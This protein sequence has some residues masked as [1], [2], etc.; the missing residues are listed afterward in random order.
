MPG[1]SIAGAGYLLSWTGLESF[2]AF[3]IPLVVVMPLIFF[4]N[5]RRLWKSNYHPELQRLLWLFQVSV[6]VVLSAPVVG[7]TTVRGDVY[8]LY[9]IADFADVPLL[10]LMVLAANLFVAQVATLLFDFLL[11]W[12]YTAS[13]DSSGRVF[14]RAALTAIPPLAF[15]YGCNVVF[16]SAAS[17]FVLA[18]I[19]PV[20]AGTF[21]VEL[22]LRDRSVDLKSWPVKDL[23]WATVGVTIT[24]TTIGGVAIVVPYLDD[25]WLSLADS[26]LVHSWEPDLAAL[27]LTEDELKRRIRISAASARVITLAYMMVIVGGHLLWTVG[28]VTA[29]YSEILSKDT[30]SEPAGA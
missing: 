3:G 22:T 8:G 26:S 28:R 12:Q 29:N 6:F 27:G 25:S 10:A 30:A 21:M 4:M 11:K 13:V 16:A 5:F 23:F 19:F 1:V 2:W 18:I 20:L 17:C 9:S 14:Q 15:I 24:L 7:M